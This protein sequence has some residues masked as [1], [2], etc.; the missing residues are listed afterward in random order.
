MVT[1]MV[2]DKHC[3]RFSTKLYNVYHICQI[4]RP[5]LTGQSSDEQRPQPA[6]H[7]SWLDTPSTRN[8]VL[9]ATENNWWTLHSCVY[10]MVMFVFAIIFT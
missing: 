3:S 10:M 5:Y 4:G 9:N 8:S 2:R 6:S 7:V 1:F